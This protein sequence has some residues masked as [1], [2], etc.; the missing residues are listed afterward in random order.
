MEH[1]IGAG[2]CEGVMEQIW[3]IGTVMRISG[4]KY[5]KLNAIELAM[6]TELKSGI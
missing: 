1:V 2:M 3:D 6:E 4:M 5:Y